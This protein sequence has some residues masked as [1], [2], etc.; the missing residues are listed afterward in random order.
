MPDEIR[1]NPDGTYSLSSE[2]VAK[3]EKEKNKIDNYEVYRLTTEED[4]RY[5]CWDCPGGTIYL[6]KGMVWRY[7]ITSNDRRYSKTQLLRWGVKYTPF[8]WGDLAECRKVEKDYI[9]GYPELPEYP[10]V[11]QLNEIYL[12][13]PPGNKE[14]N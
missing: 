10:M 5:I 1:K 11:V 14:D 3:K 7:G 6:R 2:R 4:G 8:Y 9:Y 13:R 12:I